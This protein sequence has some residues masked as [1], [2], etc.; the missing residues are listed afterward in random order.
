[1]ARTYVL[2]GS[3]G[4]QQPLEMYRRAK[5]AAETAL[6]LDDNCADAHAALACCSMYS[7]W[8]WESAEVSFQ[9]AFEL[10]PLSATAHMWYAD[11]LTAIRRH[12]EAM[13][14]IRM[15]RELDPLSPQI[16]A[17]VAWVLLYAGF[18]RE[19]VEEYRR[20][21]TI[22]PDFSPTH[23]GLG[24]AYS[25]VGRFAE[26]AD[27]LREAIACSG[28]SPS[29][30]AAL[31]HVL[32]QSG[33]KSEA[34]DVLTQLRE[35]SASRYVSAYDMAIVTW[36]IGDLEQTVGWLNK[37]CRERPTEMVYLAVDPRF[38]EFRALE[39]A[40]QLTRRFGFVA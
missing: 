31:G 32:A 3:S 25:R 13:A 37:A 8:N 28:R 36:G 6:A 9:R 21:V 26:A 39:D 2:L 14:H 35:L 5:L 29:M 24:I 23:W 30:L 33:K 15:A 18:F 12:D 16:S 4:P 22:D 17:D 34:R 1:L 10:D 19:A 11:F 27:S 38:E 40:R 20:L 7:E